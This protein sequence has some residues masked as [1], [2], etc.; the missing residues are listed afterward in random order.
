ML[1][2]PRDLLQR[3]PETL[4]KRLALRLRNAGIKLV[5][6]QIHGSVGILEC[7]VANSYVFLSSK[8]QLH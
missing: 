8:Q 5:K 1:A 3:P 6:F 4:R 2:L 7:S